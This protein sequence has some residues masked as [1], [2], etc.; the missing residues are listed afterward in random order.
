MGVVNVLSKQCLFTCSVLDAAGFLTNGV[1]GA[2]GIV[3]AFKVPMSEM[4]DPPVGVQSPD[5][6]AELLF[7]EAILRIALP[8]FLSSL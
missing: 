6:P 2:F 5:R 4:L 8:A 7:I 1:V 3:G